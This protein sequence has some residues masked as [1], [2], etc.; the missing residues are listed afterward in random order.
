MTND[1]SPSGSIVRS[2]IKRSFSAPS[3]SYRSAG[4]ERMT[5]DDSPS[6]E[7]RRMTNCQRSTESPLRAVVAWLQ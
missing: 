7:E 5:R 6:S 1:T 2:N 3:S 4:G